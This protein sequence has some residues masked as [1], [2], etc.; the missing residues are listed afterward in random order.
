MLSNALASNTFFQVHKKLRF[1]LTI[2]NNCIQS[3][4]PLTITTT[5][6]LPF[7]QIVCWCFQ[8]KTFGTLICCFAIYKKRRY[9]DDSMPYRWRCGASDGWK[10]RNYLVRYYPKT[11]KKAFAVMYRT[12]CVQ[13]RFGVT[14]RFPANS[15]HLYRKHCS[16][17]EKW[18]RAAFPK[19]TL[20]TNSKTPFR[21]P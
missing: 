12:T 5:R 4:T 7:G 15:V 3:F 20:A 8:P 11:T 6:K 9:R 16:Q 19:D 17:S 1:Q 13:T 14:S 18:L 10:K 2:A 21:I